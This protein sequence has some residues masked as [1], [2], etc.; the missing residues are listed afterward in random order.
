MINLHF[1]TGSTIAFI[2][3]FVF[4]SVKSSIYFH[5]DIPV[6]PSK[7]NDVNHQLPKVKPTLYYTVEK[8]ALTII[9]VLLLIKPPIC[10]KRLIAY[11]C[12][13]GHKQFVV[14]A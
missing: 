12:N 10:R 11:G 8:Y 7:I 6:L 14:D 9:Y 2:S 1:V 3:T 4:P 13:H 5:P